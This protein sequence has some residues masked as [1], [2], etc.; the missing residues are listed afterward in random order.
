MFITN[1]HKKYETHICHHCSKKD[2]MFKNKI[3]EDLKIIVYHSCIARVNTLV[4]Q[5]HISM[6]AS[7]RKNTYFHVIMTLYT[8]KY[9]WKFVAPPISVPAI[10]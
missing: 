6:F 9:H 2:D 4:L 3:I 5:K 8:S 7:T 10:K 1:K